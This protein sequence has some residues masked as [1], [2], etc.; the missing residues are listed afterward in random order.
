VSEQLEQ[1]AQQ[2]GDLF[3]QTGQLTP[4]QLGEQAMREQLE[5]LAEE[6]QSV[7][8][9]LGELSEQEGAQEE[10][11]GDL[12][13]LARE[14]QALAEQLARGRLEPETIRRQERL[15]HRLLDAG[16]SLEREEEESEE[17]ESRTGGVFE[18]AE[19]LP[20]GAEQLGALRYSLPDAEQLQRL[21]P[22]VRQL[23]IQYFERLNRVG[24]SVPPAGAPGPSG[25]GGGR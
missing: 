7:A 18:R 10:S 24:G 11:L 12:E 2:Q 20:L 23:V 8:E 4:L 16:R 5:R 14:A 15:F 3:N 25:G 21:S 1:L 6:Q 9:D 17:R 22:A 13:A 19:I